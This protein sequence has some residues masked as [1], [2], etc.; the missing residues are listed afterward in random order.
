MITNIVDHR[1]R[2]YRWANIYAVVEATAG[3]NSVADADQ[4][5]PSAGDVMYAEKDSGSLCD[6]VTWANSLPG[7]N[8]LYL[9][10][11]APEEVKRLKGR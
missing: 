11:G 7:H 8:T 4:I 9:Y 3:D 1:K 5:T 6:A 2:P 10:D